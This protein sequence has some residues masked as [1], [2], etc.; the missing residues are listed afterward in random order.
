MSETYLT[1]LQNAATHSAR[2]YEQ[3]DNS[4]TQQ[5][6]I[7][8]QQGEFEVNAAFKAAGFAEE[9]RQNDIQAQNIKEQ[10]YYRGQEFLMEKQLYPLKVQSAQ[11]ALQAQKFNY[12]KSRE[13]HNKQV[14]DSISGP[15]DD[16]QGFDLLRTENV[17]HAREYNNYKGKVQAYVASGGEFDAEKYKEGINQINSKY[18]DADSSKPPSYSEEYQYFLEKISPKIAQTYAKKKDPKVLASKHTIMMSL[19]DAGPSELKE[20]GQYRGMFDN[21]EWAQGMI[22]RSFSQNNEKNISRWGSELDKSRNQYSIGIANGIDEE[23]LSFIKNNIEFYEENITKAQNQNEALYKNTALGKYG[24]KEAVKIDTASPGNTEQGDERFSIKNYGEPVKKSGLGPGSDDDS[25]GQQM[26]SGIDATHKAL[27]STRKI[28]VDG[29]EV[30]ARDPVENTELALVDLRWYNDNA[31]GNEP[32]IESKQLIKDRVEE[33]VE[34]MDVKERFSRERV[35]KLLNTIKKDIDIP[36]S[37]RLRKLIEESNTNSIGI[38]RTPNF[39]YKK[40]NGNI[41]DSEESMDSFITFGP[42]KTGI[43]SF[44]DQGRSVQTEDQLFDLISSMPN[45][46][47]QDKAKKIMAMQELHSV[48]ITA[49]VSSALTDKSK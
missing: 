20:L 33:R 49:S 5:L 18:K 38:N 37:E 3:I 23:R 28:N 27:A 34:K 1:L 44:V 15:F 26:R 2:I 35:G 29:K 22:G 31:T 6:K 24:S 45:K 14:F 10:N 39:I 40:N 16:A 47:T 25:T 11:L 41:R 9:Q 42:K 8:S 43:A 30:E 4:M 48:L 36:I 7:Q 19:Y 12:V 21:E 46:T 32:D 17:D 13:V